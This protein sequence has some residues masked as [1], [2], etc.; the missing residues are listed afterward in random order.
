M[1]LKRN[2][3]DFKNLIDN[4][5]LQWIYESLSDFYRL[6]GVEGP[7]FYECVV[8]KNGGSDQI[9]FEANYL[10]NE[11]VGVKLDTKIST[12]NTNEIIGQVKITDG[13]DVVGI[14]DVAGEKALKVDV[15]QSV[16]GGGG[17]SQYTDG[18]AASAKVGNV[19]LGTDGTNLQF[20]KTDVDG[21]LQVDVL[22]LPSLPVGTNNIGDVDVLTLPNIILRDGSGN[23]LQSFDLD[24]TGGTAKVLGVTLRTLSNGTPVQHGTVSDP[25]RVDPVGTTPQPITDNGGSITVDG[26]I[27]ANQGG[28]WLMDITDKPARDLGKVDI[29]SFDVALPTG[30]NTIGKVDQGLP[31]TT[32]DSWPVKITDGTT[33]A[34]VDAG[35]SRL[36]VDAGTTSSNEEPTFVAVSLVTQIGNNK[37]MMSIVNTHATLRVKIKQIIIRNQQTTGIAGVMADFRLF[38]CTGHSAGTLVTPQARDTDDTLNAA[39]TCRTGATIAGEAASPMDRWKWSSDDHG[40]GT[41]DQEGLDKA[42]MNCFPMTNITDPSEKRITLRQNQGITLKQVTNSTNGNF[43]II[44]VFTV[45]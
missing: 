7:F 35:T 36:K 6:V 40:V 37:S 43:D 25:I 5:Q 34:G 38:R 33:I 2:W 14:S 22:S 27:T 13:V 23:E 15:I 45:V 1:I 11:T 39:I 9:D 28:S 8:T 18:T 44:I 10:G 41:L 17:G 4:N 24:N 42:F 26:S 21:E 16:G 19:I 32:A 3:T 31:T 20:I 30:T 29:A 12:G